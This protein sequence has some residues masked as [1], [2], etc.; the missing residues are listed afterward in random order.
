MQQHGSKY[1]TCRSHH[2]PHPSDP[3]VR[4]KRSNSPFLNMIRLQ[5]KLKGITKCSNNMKANILP[6]D[7]PPSPPP[8]RPFVKIQLLQNMVML[9]QNMVTLHIKINGIMKCSNMVLN[10][11]ARRP[12]PHTHTHTRPW[13]SKGQN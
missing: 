6:A 9:H 3:V 10:H 13:G 2:Q 1:F 12:P 7:P 8:P 4:V 11:F 5:I